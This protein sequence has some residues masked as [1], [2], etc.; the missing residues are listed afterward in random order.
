MYTICRSK[1]R[2]VVILTA[3]AIT[4]GVVE[5]QDCERIYLDALR[6]PRIDLFTT[7]RHSS[8]LTHN[9]PS[10]LFLPERRRTTRTPLKHI[11]LLL[12]D[13]FV[14]FARKPETPGPSSDTSWFKRLLN[15]RAGT[16]KLGRKLQE[17]E[18]VLTIER[19]G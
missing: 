2:C 5:L 8:L 7:N 13:L 17:P 19:I 12:F 14:R 3:S 1:G 9:P 10:S 11:Q 18:H 15:I 6:S 4:I 16:V